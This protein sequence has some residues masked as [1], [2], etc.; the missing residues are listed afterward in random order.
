M[1]ASGSVMPTYWLR[2]SPAA[3]PTAA[4]TG[5]AGPAR[6]PP[7]AAPAIGR[8]LVS[9][10]PGASRMTSGGGAAPENGTLN[11]RPATAEAASA[12]SESGPMEGRAGGAGRSTAGARDAPTGYHARTSNGLPAG[13]S[14]MTEGSCTD[15]SRIVFDG[16]GGGDAGPSHSETGG[17]GP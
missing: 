7:I 3:A 13:P 4:P 16:G 14:M 15:C 6:V 5:A 8:A 17:T 1:F 11:G 9:T 10:A 12:K 2:P